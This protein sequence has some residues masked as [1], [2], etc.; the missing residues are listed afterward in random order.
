M[1]RPP[2]IMYTIS[3]KIS[4]PDSRTCHSHV[5]HDSPCYATRAVYQKEQWLFIFE[6]VIVPRGKGEIMP[7][8][9]SLTPATICYV[10]LCAE[11]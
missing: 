5:Q 4:V 7:R 10:C 9:C 8:G 6:V 3:T 2:H 1:P 11:F